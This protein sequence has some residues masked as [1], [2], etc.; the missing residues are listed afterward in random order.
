VRAVVFDGVGRVRVD[1]VPDPH[2]E[3]AG[4]AVL[5]LTCSAICGSD[6]HFFHGKAPMAPGESIGHEA[7]GVVEETGAGVT[8]FA[9]GDRVVVAFDIVCGACW[10]CE[11]GQTQLCEDFRNLGAGAFG[12]G[13]A[14]A[15]AERLRVPTA[16]VNLLAV[17]GGVTDEAALFVGDVLTTGWYAASIAGIRQEDTVAVVGVGPVGYCTVQAALTR[18][19][20]QVLALDRDPAR[21]ALAAA[22]GA[23]PVDVTARH[24]VTA[25]AEATGGRGADVVVEAVGHPDA[26]ETAADVAR[27]GATVVVVGMYMG[28]TVPMQ[29]GVWWARAIDLRFSGVCPVHAWWEDAMAELAA[30]RLDPMPLVSHRLPLEEAARGYELFDRREAT[31]VLLVP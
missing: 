31:K 1:D 22:A 13:L 30:G 4:D 28:E 11:R 24:P 19:P 14:G 18:N 25:V 7:V 16:D 9:P 6:L 27:R 12:G 5:R 2:V 3:E 8:R 17:P 15:Q 21:L 20:R 23:L 29:L 26:F 10:F